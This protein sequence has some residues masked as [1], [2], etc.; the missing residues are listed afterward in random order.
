M[1][2]PNEKEDLKPE[3][4]NDPYRAIASYTDIQTARKMY[5]L[6]NGQQVIFTK[7]WYSKD[8]VKKYVKENFQTYSIKELSQKF[9]YTD[10]TIRQMLNDKL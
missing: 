4:L 5:K 2:D 6:L 1:I 3:N 7:K 10:R 8:Y 9:N